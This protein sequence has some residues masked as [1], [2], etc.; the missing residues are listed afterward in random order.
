[1]E[2]SVSAVGW[3]A[4]HW[5]ARQVFLSFAFV[6]L[7]AEAPAGRTGSGREAKIDR[8]WAA[9]ERALDRFEQEFPRARANA[10]ARALE[11]IASHLGI[12]L[13]TRG[14]RNRS[15]PSKVQRQ[16][17]QAIARALGEYVRRE[18]VRPDDRIEEPPEAVQSFF[19]SR[20]AQLAAISLLGPETPRW[21]M[22]VRAGPGA[23]VLNI[24]GQL[25]LQKVL[26]A[27]ALQENARGRAPEAERFLEVSWRLNQIALARPELISQ[28]LA[29]AVCQLQVGVLRK[30]PVPPAEWADRL[31][32]QD[33]RS[34]VFSSLDNEAL[35]SAYEAK[36]QEAKRDM[37]R[38]VTATRQVVARFELQNPCEFSRRAADRAWRPLFSDRDSAFV[39][40]IALPNLSN[41]VHRLFRAL[42]DQEL[43]EKVLQAKS[44]RLQ[45]EDGVWPREMENLESCV[46]PG[47]S[48]CY[49]VASDGMMRISFDGFFEEW[50]GSLALKLPLT[51]TTG[52]ARSSPSASR[53][54]TRTLSMARYDG[55]TSLRPRD[56]LA[57]VFMPGARPSSHS[58]GVAPWQAL[59]R[60]VMIL[61][62]GLP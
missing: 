22:N 19:A 39:V 47:A 8:Q 12:D 60:H 5:L 3:S 35:L 26:I 45:L 14:A 6:P 9:I 1:M 16:E 24:Q 32:K 38:Y 59:R 28:I 21:E 37:I 27:A 2:A 17:F 15:R 18:A 55:L 44:A 50:P 52:G 58:T 30:L 48:W 23:P 11:D 20:A 36:E 43:T 62:G 51:F 46:C 41:T 53:P 10:S 57:S 4:R 25:N 61:I 54:Q 42:L 7:V 29:I 31:R 13:A 34:R 56:S 49:R 40:S 33:L